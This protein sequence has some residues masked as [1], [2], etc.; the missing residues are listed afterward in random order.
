[1]GKGRKKIDFKLARLWERVRRV[2]KRFARSAPW[3]SFPDRDGG[4][5]TMCTHALALNAEALKCIVEVYGP[6]PVHIEP[7]QRQAR[8]LH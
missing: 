2:R 6:K 7:L 3:V 8:E 4:E 1:M 5:H